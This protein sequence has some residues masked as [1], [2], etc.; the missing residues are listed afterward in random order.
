MYPQITCHLEKLRHNAA[1]VAA[2]CHQAGIHL[3]A[4]TKGVCANRDVVTAISRE[5]VDSLGD[6][7]LLNLAT[8]P[9]DKPRLLVRLADP[10]QAEQVVTHSHISLQSEHTAIRA[11]GQ[12]AQRLNKPHQVILMI[13]LGDLRE[14]LLYTHR[15][16]ILRTAQAVKEAPWLTLQ[17]VGTNL[18]CFGGILPGQENLGQLVDIAAWL[19]RELNLPIPWVSGGNSSSLGMVF[20]GQMPPGV[21]HLRVGESILL[22]RDTTTGQPF[23]QLRQD[24]FTLSA[25]LGEVQTKPS[26]PIG[27]TGPNAFGEEVSFPD[28]GPMRR[29]ILLVG[30][31]DTDWQGLT[32]RDS[33]VKVLGASSDHLLVDVTAAPDLKVGDVLHFDVR[34][35]AL[36]QAYTSRYVSKACQ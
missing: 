28:L 7:R 16:D 19:R 31:Q 22:G 27:E 9:G 4:V 26:Q 18:T 23:P 11:L 34:Y 36:L 1:V 29:G 8:L 5:A 35:G 25:R 12:V 13:D 24:V 15:E 6:S 3:C 33:R 14:G 10:Q 32:P 20:S 17:G 21:N 30:R 2:A